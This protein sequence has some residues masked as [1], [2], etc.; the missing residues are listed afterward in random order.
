MDPSAPHRR[1]GEP[2]GPVEPGSPIEFSSPIEFT[3]RPDR[4]DP[5]A[6]V[7]EF[8]QGTPA[9]RWALS[10]YLIGRAIIE[11]VGISMLVVAVLFFAIAAACEWWLHQT[12]AAVLALIFGL[13]TLLVRAASL[14]VLRRVTAVGRFGPHEDR[15]NALVKQTRGDVLRELRRLGLPGRSLTLPWLAVRLLGRRRNA[16][17]LR[18]RGFDIDRVVSPARLD[19]LHLLW[20][21]AFGDADP[22][23]APRP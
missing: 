22:G 12:A 15:M 17:L 16:T 14:A 2:S 18:L 7:G 13:V 19:E 20:T 6:E 10:R 8:R 9:S 3:K 4:T 5:Q 23:A 21:G 11:A 1:S